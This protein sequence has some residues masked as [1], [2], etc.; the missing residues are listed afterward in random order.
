ME[1]ESPKKFESGDTPEIIGDTDTPESGIIIK[2]EYFLNEEDKKE[3]TLIINNFTGK[4]NKISYEEIVYS[5]YLFLETITLPD[6]IKH[7]KPDN[8]KCDF[9]RYLYRDG[10]IL[11]EEKES[12]ILDEYLNT[13]NLKIMIKAT[14]Y[15]DDEFAIIKKFDIIEKEIDYTYSQMLGKNLDNSPADAPLNLVVL[16]AN[17]L[18]GEKNELRTMNDFNIITSTIYKL[19]DDEDYLKY[20]EFCPLTMNTLKNILSNKAK[21][22][23]ILHL[24]CKSTYIQDNESKKYNANLIFEKNYNNDLTI[25]NYKLEFVNVNTLI[26]E[27][28]NGES[29][30]EI[31]ENI[32][33]ITLIISTQLA[34]DVYKIF[35][36]FEFKNILV[37]HTTLA[38]VNFIAEFNKVFYQDLI[39]HLDK[40]INMIFENALN[41][42]NEQIDLKTFCCCFH[43]H[44]DTCATLENLRNDIFVDKNYPDIDNLTKEK[45]RAKEMKI[46]IPHFYHLHPVCKNYIA[47]IKKYSDQDIKIPK[48]SFSLCSEFSAKQLKYLDFFSKNNQKVKVEF[49]DDSKKTIKKNFFNFCCCNEEPKNHNINMIFQKDFNEKIKNNTIQFRKAGI[50]REKLNL[51]IYEKLKLLVGKNAFVFKALKF[52]FK[53]DFNYCNI[54]GDTEINLKIFRSILKE[55]YL[56][57]YYFYELNNKKK[58]EKEKKMN[59]DYELRRIYSMPVLNQINYNDKDNI[60]NYDSEMKLRQSHSNFSLFIADIKEI[61]EIDFKDFIKDELNNEFNNIYFIYISNAEL[62]NKNRNKLRTNNKIIFFSEKQLPKIYSMQYIELTKEPILQSNEKYYKIYNINYNNVSLNEY[63]KFQEHEIVQNWRKNK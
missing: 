13:S 32:K 59:K 51:P 39:R 12:I 37:Q 23:L 15:T 58:N 9:I 52:L 16:T 44:K 6:E 24:I 62:V 29:A 21:I 31:K 11:L 8:F 33:N 46:L 49:L 57:R 53:D 18:M 34:E 42:S 5:F 28:F 1:D 48:N 25:D 47:F 50:L 14:I 55:Y 63:I 26:K 3:G 41:T 36:K 22:P 7:I 2:L 43:S 40:P 20:T 10:W 19:F 54:Y 35:E 45:E 4:C 17:P 30:K 38:D 27:L 61:L 60:V 56:E